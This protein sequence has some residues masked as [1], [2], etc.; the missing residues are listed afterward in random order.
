VG[1]VSALV[2]FDAYRLPAPLPWSQSPPERP[3]RER[4]MARHVAIT[5][6]MVK[7]GHAALNEDTRR[8]LAAKQAGEVAPH[9]TRRP[10]AVARG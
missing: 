7:A 8:R 3:G 6:A 2:G 9:T 10:G 5:I 1:V 4:V